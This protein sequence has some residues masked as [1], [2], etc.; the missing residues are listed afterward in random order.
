MN[1]MQFEILFGDPDSGERRLVRVELSPEE[2]KAA[3]AHPHPDIARECYALRHGY[4]MVPI[5]WQH[6][7]DEIKQVSLN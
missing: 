4:R 3:A 6:Y 7:S 2:A 5:D 1:V